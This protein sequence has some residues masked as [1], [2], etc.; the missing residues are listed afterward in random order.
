MEFDVFG[1]RVIVEHRGNAWATFE[2]GDDGKR[3]SASFV[4]PPDVT[5]DDLERYL[6]DIFHEAARPGRQ[7]VRPPSFELS[8]NSR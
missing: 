4:I 5:E 6:A 1:R 7:A 2:R 3:R 8:W